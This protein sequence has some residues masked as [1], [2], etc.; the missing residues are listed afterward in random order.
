L[1]LTDD[2]SDTPPAS[3]E[4]DYAKCQRHILVDM[5]IPDWDE[6]FLSKFD[7]RRMVDLY[8]KA[9]A[10]AVMTFC[11]S[12]VGL[13]YWPTK[14]GKEHE[15]TRG[16]DLVGETVRLLHERGIAACAY[17]SSIFN[18]WA[19]ATN[20][21]WRLVPLAEGSFFG[22]GSRYGICCPNNP[23]YHAFQLAQ[24]AELSSSYPF[25]AFFFDMVFWT[26][27]CGCE[28]CRRRFRAEADAE[29]PV[30]IDWFSQ[31]W[32][33]FQSAR[34]RWLAESFADLAREVKRYRDIPVF[35]NAAANVPSGWQRGASNEL[36][37]YADVLSGDFHGGPEGLYAYGHLLARLTPTVMQYMNAF[38][39][40]VGST[41]YLKSTEEQ[42]VHH[43][44][45]ATVFGG[46][47]MAIDAIQ[48]DGSTNDAAYE[49]LA[50][51]FAAL[52]PFASALDRQPIADI[53]VYWSL[54][55][56]VNFDEN[57]TPIAEYPIGYSSRKPH[58]DAVIGACSALRS[59]LPVGV[60]S[61][62]DL[63]DLA[64]YPVVVLPNVL[65]MDDEE[66]SAIRSYVASGGRVYASGYT[67]LVSVDGVKRTDFG[68][69]DVFGCHY[70]G[71]ETSPVCYVHPSDD[72][73]RGAVRP[74]SYVPYGRDDRHGIYPRL[75]GT[76]LRV[77]GGTG[78]VVR[79][80]VTLPYADGLGTREDEKW[81]SIHTSPP[82]VDTD[83][84]AI[85]EHRYGQGTVIYCAGDLEVSASPDNEPANSLFV[86]MI[87]SLLPGAPRFE[88]ACDPGV[89]AAAFDDRDRQRV[90]LNLSNQPGLLPV[91]PVPCLRF[92]LTPPEGCS[93]TSLEHRPEDGTV[94]YS[95]GDA[96]AIEGEVHG[97]RHFIALEALYE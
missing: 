45:P 6:R 3:A 71:D 64:R 26:D 38:S 18:N 31:E 19:Y 40:Y 15:R 52:K 55:S 35:F 82:W 57:G 86:E 66:I 70:E 87:S 1:T 76:A 10:D 27:I 88:L 34:E 80:T 95:L 44:L 21:S 29:F 30:T 75:P 37:A 8:C 63:G 16:G 32:C 53:A 92:R 17:Y 96:G 94:D 93:F 77:R 7:A 51:V 89:W 23:E 4:F 97:L 67:S 69:S 85:V 33:R 49:R 65:R 13:C 78:A 24:V 43:A 73:A 62:A 41:S 25:D 58:M 46:Q 84:P 36:V 54:P 9:G 74:L 11:N 22:D 12:H 72:A 56:M 59:R 28:H 83:R 5:H 48:P 50:D 68:L 60:I 79:A 81:A 42:L 61:R 91:R 20:P 39:S 14:V 2:T 90:R 47:Y